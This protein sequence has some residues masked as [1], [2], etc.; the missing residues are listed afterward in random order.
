M[1]DVSYN[2][3]LGLFLSLALGPWTPNLYTRM[4]FCEFS[5]STVSTMVY[6]LFGKVGK[7]FVANPSF[8]LIPFAFLSLRK[9][10][11]QIASSLQSTLVLFGYIMSVLCLPIL[12]IPGDAVDNHPMGDVLVG[13]TLTLSLVHAV[14]IVMYEVP[15]WSFVC[16]PLF[17]ICYVLRMAEIERPNSI[18]GG[19]AI[20]YLNIGCLYRAYQNIDMKGHAIFAQTL[21]IDKW[22]GIEIYSAIT[23]VAGFII[24][25]SSVAPPQH[26]FTA[27]GGGQLLEICIY[28]ILL[29]AN[30]GSGLIASCGLLRDPHVTPR[31]FRL[32]LQR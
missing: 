2:I 26:L 19:I 21:S 10:C 31:P 8:V 5:R 25:C 24:I 13:D 18:F 30:V 9:V 11:P 28:I 14:L 16:G 29:N 23:V 1:R 4:G 17:G 12:F 32:L 6:E 27:R 7:T 20:L 22:A 3:A 15:A